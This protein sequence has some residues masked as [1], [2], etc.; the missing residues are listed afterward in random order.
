[1]FNIIRRSLCFSIREKHLKG[2]SVFVASFFTLLEHVATMTLV[3]VAA[4]MLAHIVVTLTIVEFVIPLVA[5]LTSSPV[6]W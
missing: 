1:M 4:V 2:P 5:L 3:H 6:M